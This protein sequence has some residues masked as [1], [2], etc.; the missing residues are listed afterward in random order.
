MTTT[1]ENA[2]VGD[3]VWDYHFGWGEIVDIESICLFP[4]SVSFLTRAPL[5]YTFTGAFQ[6]TLNQTLFW[7]E[8]KFK[9][10]TQPIQVKMKM[11]HGIE[12]PDISIDPKSTDLGKRYYYPLPS[13]VILH[14]NEFYG[15]SSHCITRLKN[16]LCYPFTEEGK[17]AA[18]LHAVA[19]LGIKE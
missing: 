4:L 5:T 15:C 19:M 18:I 9:V 6:E 3:K 11:I 14:D 13:S 16:R 8:I 7:D 10:P 12:V 2:K 1:F 17:Q